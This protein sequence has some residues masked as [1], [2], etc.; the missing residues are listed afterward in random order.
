MVAMLTLGLANVNAQKTGDAT[1]N[2]NLSKIQSLVVNPSDKVVDINYTT[3][4]HYAEG[5]TASKQNH[6]EVFST[7]G[8][9]ITAKAAAATLTSGDTDKTISIA[10]IKLNATSGNSSGVFNFPAAILTNGSEGVE[11]I[12]SA[13]GGRGLKFHMNYTAAGSDKYINHAVNS[14]SVTTYTT[15]VTYTI[16]PN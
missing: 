3:I 6:L 11:V 16:A 10:D 4:E 12:S 1:L 15:T 5:V 8:F 2:I 13:V 7:G 14:E 9:K